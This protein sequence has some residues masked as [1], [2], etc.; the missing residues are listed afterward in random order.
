M[1]LVAYEKCKLLK[2]KR[3]I[4]LLSLHTLLNDMPRDLQSYVPRKNGAI[5]ELVPTSPMHLEYTM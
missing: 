3:P 4:I 2:D 5:R 1:I